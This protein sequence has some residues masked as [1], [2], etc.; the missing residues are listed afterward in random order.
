MAGQVRP[1]PPEMDRLFLSPSVCRKK[2]CSRCDAYANWP[3]TDAQRCVVVRPPPRQ[4]L[5]PAVRRPAE[6]AAITQ[7]L[8]SEVRFLGAQLDGCA[9]AHRA[10]KRHHRAAMCEAEAEADSLRRQIQVDDSSV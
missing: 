4:V 8:R 10:L 6:A 2:L 1:P 7:K 5:P 3:T 9:V